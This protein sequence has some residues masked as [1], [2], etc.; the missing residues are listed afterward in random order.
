[1][2]TAPILFGLLSALTW[3]A[4]DFNGGLAV[5]RSNPYGVVAV[6]HILS[7]GLLLLL[8]PLVGEP[9]PPWQDWLWGGAAG[10]TGAFGLLLLYRALADGRMSVAAPVSALLAAALPVIVGIFMDGNPGAWVLFGFFLALAAVWLVS[11]GEGLAI[12]FDELRQPIIAGIAFGTFFICLERASQT[13]LLWPLVAI[14]IVSITS[15][16]GYALVTRQAWIPKR[17][18]LVPIV[19][20]SILDTIGNAAYALSARTGRLDVAAVLGSLYPGATVLLAWVF[21]KENISRIQTIGILLALG[22]I[23]L[24]TL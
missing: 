24:L 3:G 20:S 11:G 21:L 15:M 19:L 17:E 16:L 4:G 12:R 14:R 23:I 13:S 6:A 7:L 18:S 22:A 10:L 8:I 2:L 1:M 9:I 5:K